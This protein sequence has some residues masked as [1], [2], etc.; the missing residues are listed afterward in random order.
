MIRE[1]DLYTNRLGQR[2]AADCDGMLVRF[3]AEVMIVPEMRLVT[4]LGQLGYKCRDRRTRGDLQAV[5]G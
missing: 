2:T 1:G 4:I 3:G 5:A